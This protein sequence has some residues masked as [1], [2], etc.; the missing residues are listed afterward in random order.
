M[1]RRMLFASVLTVCLAAMAPAALADDPVKDLLDQEVPALKDGT[2]MTPEAVEK[3]ILDACARRKFQASVVEPGLISARW[4]HG[5]HSFQVSIPYN[6][7][8]YSIRYQHSERMDYNPARH[9]IDD[10]YNDYVAGL[11][12]HIDAGLENTL[13]R[14]R[15]A[16]KPAKRVARFNPRTAV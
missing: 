7:S 8:S 9:R 14:I 2:R 4:V 12:E 16:L 1:K 13:D 6:E 15:K 5:S 11:A 10:A 3:A